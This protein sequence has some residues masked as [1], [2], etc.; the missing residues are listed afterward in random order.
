ML[1]RFYL[2]TASCAVLSVM[3]ALPA[4]AR[5]PYGNGTSVS[6]DYSQVPAA[7]SANWI[8]APVSMQR[9]APIQMQPARQG[10]S[11]VTGLS[12]PTQR[13][14]RGGYMMQPS[15]Q[16]TIQRYRDYAA[17]AP[18]EATPLPPIEAAKPAP[19][20]TAEASVKQADK[21]QVAEA[22]SFA[23]LKLTPPVKTE[24][25]KPE[26][27]LANAEPAK[28][29][30]EARNLKPVTL[31]PP[32][33]RKSINEMLT[34]NAADKTEKQNTK[35]AVK[36]L[37]D[38][39]IEKPVAVAEAKSDVKAGANVARAENNVPPAIKETGR[40]TAEQA[41]AL[42]GQRL[43]KTM[44]TATVDKVRQAE[45]APVLSQPV[46]EPAAPEPVAP[47]KDVELAA[48]DM[49]K[50]VQSTLAPIPP[51]EIA[52]AS[53]DNTAPKPK[54]AI[55]NA[56]IAPTKASVLKMPPLESAKEDAKPESQIMAEAKPA[57]AF[58]D[59]NKKAPL[60][61]AKIASLAVP[62]EL[63]QPQQVNTESARGNDAPAPFEKASVKSEPAKP[64]EQIADVPTEVKK[65]FIPAPHVTTKIV[66][67]P[68]V[69]QPVSS[70]SE[71]E[72]AAPVPVKSASSE[73]VYSK[74][75]LKT[76]APVAAR[77]EQNAASKAETKAGS[78]QAN[79][80]LARAAYD[81]DV[82][83]KKSA[84]VK[85]SIPQ[86]T[87][88]QPAAA[89]SASVQTAAIQPAVVLK[90]G[91]VNSVVFPAETVDVASDRAIELDQLAMQMENDPRVHV[92]LK[93]YAGKNNASSSDARRVSLKRALAVRDYLIGKGVPAS[94]IDVRALGY[95]EDAVNPPDRVDLQAM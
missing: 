57:T 43:A 9:A 41:S 58:E 23:P 2:A 78:V 68:N 74:G 7:P 36:I 8:A 34:Q 64:S 40:L 46:S 93:S 14:Q 80:D 94:R 76:A 42:E 95:V 72:I 89:Q 13:Y 20:K 25:A 21:G 50:K 92:Q 91:K 81:I 28:P 71:N 10:Y 86:G 18:I 12:T 69:E 27:T 24:M 85:A 79:R 65:P 88:T 31:T 35:S 49:Q 90:T 61:S 77:I 29:V 60:P 3:I 45:V 54:T 30:Q 37:A 16:A 22:R 55:S 47:K 5:S 66:N 56:L 38:K 62:P 59:D 73:P 19:V 48:A 67:L 6:V 53:A 51:R 87:I 70:D 4:H 15:T 26:T 1:S 52:V 44:P 82:N 84:A 17:S 75:D 83:A 39:P 32:A 33:P 11:N 63:P